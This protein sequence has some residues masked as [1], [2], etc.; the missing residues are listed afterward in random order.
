M[1]Y[2]EL[3]VRIGHLTCILWHPVAPFVVRRRVC[4]QNERS[5]LRQSGSVGG[6]CGCEKGT[7]HVHRPCF[8]CS[9]TFVLM[10]Y[11]AMA[12]FRKGDV[13]TAF[14]LSNLLASGTMDWTPTRPMKVTP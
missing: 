7:G 12:G 10:Q 6:S 5:C 14:T 13:E 8:S 3:Q 1:E 9:L 2:G 11:C 4:V